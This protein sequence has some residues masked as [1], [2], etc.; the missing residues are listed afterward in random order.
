MLRQKPYGGDQPWR[1]KRDATRGALP[2]AKQCL[3][4]STQQFQ[5]TIAVHLEQDGHSFTWYVPAVMGDG[6]TDDNWYPYVFFQADEAGN[7]DPT[8]AAEKRS[9][10]FRG[11][12]PTANGQTE[13]CWLVH[14]GDLK[15]GDQ[16]YF[17]PATLDFEWLDTA[18][19]RF[20]IAYDEQSGRR[21]GRLTRPYL[22]DDLSTL[23]AAWECIG[24]QEGLTSSQIYALRDLVEAKREAWFD[25]PAQSLTSEPFRQLCCDAVVNAEWK[26]PPSNEQNEKVVS[27]L[28]SGLFA[29]MVELFMSIMK[30]KPQ[31]NEETL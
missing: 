7:T 25:R 26:K 12:R 21:R 18:A 15:A 2:G 23:T 29:D 20:A 16:V 5:Q 9:Q 3:A 31:R 8:Q 24:G 27:W 13:A 22:L 14:A 10:V 17:T 11:V 30:A 19:R 6:H 4:K 28:V 1:V